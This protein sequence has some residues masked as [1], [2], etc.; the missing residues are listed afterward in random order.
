ME[1][2]PPPITITDPRAPAGEDVLG[3]EPWT[4]SPRHRRI[5]LVTTV[6]LVLLGGA[7]LAVAGV[8]H[9]RAADRAA[10]AAVQL[11]T[12]V[13]SDGPP[14]GYV[15]VA[16]RNDGPDAVR[17]LSARLVPGGYDETALHEQLPSGGLATVE[18]EDAAP[19]G[20]ALL[21]HPP[22]AVRVRLRTVRGTVV[23]RELALSPGPYHDATHA[24]QE[25]CGYLPA[26]EAFQLAVTSVSVH[27][28]A[29]VLR[30]TA[31]DDSV[32]PLTLLRLREAPGLSL[33]VTPAL[34]LPL[35]PQPAA[36]RVR[37]VVTLTL[38]LR[39]SRCDLFLSA[40]GYPQVQGVQ[41]VVRG[42]V[43]RAGVDTEVPVLD[44]GGAQPPTNVDVPPGDPALV[45]GHLL[46]RCPSLVVDHAP[47]YLPE[48]P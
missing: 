27:G 20:P 13:S 39:V 45:L 28:P 43:R 41:Q 11:A 19:C 7:A 24:A 47:E 46:T 2:E 44:A 34:P 12:D 22:S 5:A 29:V 23:T 4:L 15:G 32:L 35:P 33:S 31:Y 18:F 10:L 16:L 38:R 8:R 48:Q 36:G 9:D 6:V 17:L 37:H 14:Q 30:A 1:P 40:L 21:S 25:R 42:W 26:E 3:A